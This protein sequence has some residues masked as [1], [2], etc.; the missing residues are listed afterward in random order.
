[1]AKPIKLKVKISI[2]EDKIIVDYRGS[3]KQR[4]RQPINVPYSY[5]MSDTFYALQYILF[6]NIQNIG[7][8]YCP[9]E[10][11]LDEKSILNASKPV[12]VFARCRTGLH[13]SALLNFTLHR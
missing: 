10:I 8:Q 9:V 4:E 5:T 12:P 6:D 13:I 1:M 2:S 11:I 3:D 7:T